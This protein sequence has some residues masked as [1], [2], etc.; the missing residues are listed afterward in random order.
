MWHIHGWSGIKGYGL[1][2]LRYMEVNT[3]HT[4]HDEE[5]YWTAYHEQLYSLAQTLNYK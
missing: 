1:K 2:T 3:V 4:G 5:N